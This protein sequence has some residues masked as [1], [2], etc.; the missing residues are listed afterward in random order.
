M[1]KLFPLL[2]LIL[3]WQGCKEKSNVQQVIFTTDSGETEQYFVLRD[4]ESVKH[5]LYLRLTASGDTLEKANYEQGM[6]N[7]ERMLY[8]PG[9]RLKFVEH[10]SANQFEGVF[11]AF[12][13]DGAPKIDGQ[14]LNGQ[15]DGEW[16]YYYQE[17]AGAVKEKVSFRNN[18][19]NGPFTEY[20]P[21]GKIAAEGT[22]ENEME[23]GELKIYDSTGKLIRI[24]VFTGDGPPKIIIP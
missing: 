20:H 7:G 5:G 24:Q 9:G 13:E 18:S 19:E 3:L 12:F 8:Y 16:I 22:Y 15:M 10:Y 1:K 11:K 17:P 6:L 4:E 14:Y 21:N 2:L 23:T